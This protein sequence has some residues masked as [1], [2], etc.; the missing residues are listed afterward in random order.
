MTVSDIRDTVDVSTK[1]KELR[2]EVLAKR[3]VL[4]SEERAIGSVRIFSKIAEMDIYQKAEIILCYVDFGSEVQTKEFMANA[5]ADGKTVY[6]PRIVREDDGMRRMRFYRYDAQTLERSKWGIEEPP[7][8]PSEEYPG[9]SD[10]KCLVIVPGTVFD[11]TRGR[12]GYNGGFYDRFLAAHP[13]MKTCA[14]AFDLQIVPEV[15]QGI[16]DIKPKI[17]VTPGALY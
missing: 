10:E 7:Q 1:K 4:S 3:D 6:A 8:C 16:Y 9:T 12:L 2:R 5:K 17:I 13:A 11:R 14:V 15:P